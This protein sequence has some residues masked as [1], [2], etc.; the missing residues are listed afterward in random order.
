[1]S[2]LSDLDLDADVQEDNGTG[3]GGIT[4]IPKGKYKFVIVK[5]DVRAT[6]DNNGKGIELVLQIVDGQ[7]SDTI[8]KDWINLKNKNHPEAEKI[9]QGQYKRICRI[10]GVPF[11]PPD[12]TQTFGK[13]ILGTVTVVP[14]Y[15]D[16]TKNVNK[17]TAYNPVPS[18]FVAEASLEQPNFIPEAS[19]QPA[20]D[21]EPW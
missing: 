12:S 15:K 4:L 13:P 18:D 8:L 20:T 16:K 17:I 2:N 10:A 1:M 7:Y 14:Y 3:T 19:N 21:D 11:P 5:D 6:S 9:G